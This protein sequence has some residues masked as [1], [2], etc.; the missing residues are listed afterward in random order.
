[1]QEAADLKCVKNLEVPIKGAG[2]S[3][4]ALDSQYLALIADNIDISLG[5][6]NHECL[7]N[8]DCLKD[9]ENRKSARF[10]QEHPEL[11][12]LVT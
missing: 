5:T 12:S 8:I 4:A 6:D 2:N 9:D 3:F 10:E 7:F 11:P 1:M